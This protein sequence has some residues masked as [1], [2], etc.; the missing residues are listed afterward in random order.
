[1][2]SD[3]QGRDLGVGDKIAANGS[4]LFEKLDN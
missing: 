4:C 3:G 1:M 2:I